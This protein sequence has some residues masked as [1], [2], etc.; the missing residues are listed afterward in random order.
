MEIP[1]R[2]PQPYACPPPPPANTNYTEKQMEFLF[3][4][5]K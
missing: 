3:N 5:S 4:S 1:V 2:R